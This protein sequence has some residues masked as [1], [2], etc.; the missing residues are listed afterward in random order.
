MSDDKH[1][2]METTFA[3]TWIAAREERVPNPEGAAGALMTLIGERLDIEQIQYEQ[4]QN[5]A[6]FLFDLSNLGLPGM[7]FNVMMIT[8]AP[9][10]EAEQISFSELL[11]GYKNSIKSAG[12]CFHIILHD[13]AIPGAARNALEDNVV[14]LNGS[15]LRR[16]F[17]EPFPQPVLYGVIRKQIPLTSLCPYN[18]QHGARGAMF[19]NRLWELNKLIYE[20]GNSYVVSGARRIGKSSLLQRAFDL[21]RH[22]KG[23]AS[24]V[25]HYDCRNWGNYRDCCR[26]VLREIDPKEAYDLERPE[27]VFVQRIRKLSRDRGKPLIL[28]L[29]ELDRVLETDVRTNRWTF[30]GM[31]AELAENGV[32][33]LVC[34]GYR[35]VSMLCQHAQSPFFEKISP[36]SVPPFTREITHRLIREPMQNLDI[37]FDRVEVV[38]QRIWMATA[39]YPFMVQYLGEQ[40]FQKVS[41]SGDYTIR[42]EDIDET[43]ND[44]N[45]INFIYSHFLENTRV[46]DSPQI[47]ERQCSVV[48]ADYL[49]RCDHHNGWTDQDFYVH[50]RDHH[51]PLSADKIARALRNLCNAAVLLQKQGKYHFAFPLVPHV[52]KLKYPDLELFLESLENH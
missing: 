25:Y 4:T 3:K 18:T 46:N 29:D 45:T 38:L 32:I 37:R 42:V 12:Y 11:A 23:F 8:H 30:A 10:T 49:S 40:L 48:F 19:F 39:G 50:C 21:L 13:E 35:S 27:D 7:D 17:V 33:R 6:I 28:F 26:K 36:L 44:A 47:A 9:T 20:L 34:A 52:L 31:L 2:T 15:D 5:A 16:L 43:E 51:R 1:A 24:R 14:K 22:R 41:Q